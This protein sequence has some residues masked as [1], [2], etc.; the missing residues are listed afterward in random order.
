MT[1]EELAKKTDE[2][3]SV[4]SG[5]NKQ[6]VHSIAHLIRSN[7]ILDSSIKSFSAN[8]KRTEII[9]ICLAVA[10]ILLVII[11]PLLK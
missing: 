9:M 4:T 11:S 3:A 1:Q 5:P 10:Q 2:I 6:I 8:T 7:G